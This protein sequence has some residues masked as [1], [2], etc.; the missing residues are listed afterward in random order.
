MLKWEKWLRFVPFKHIFWFLHFR[1]GLYLTQW[2]PN[3]LHNMA[4]INLAL[5]Q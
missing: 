3:P 4:G 2:N 5:L 1:S